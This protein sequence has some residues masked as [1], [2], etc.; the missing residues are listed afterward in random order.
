VSRK[1]VWTAVALLVAVVVAAL[2]V[3]KFLEFVASQ[4]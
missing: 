3:V 1:I 2:V 4:N